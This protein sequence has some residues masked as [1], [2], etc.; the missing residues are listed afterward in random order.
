MCLLTSMTLHHHCCH[1]KEQSGKRSRIRVAAALIGAEDKVLRESV[2]YQSL[3]TAALL[4]GMKSN[5][6]HLTDI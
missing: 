3:T 2:W 1:G 5:N 6:T 4:W